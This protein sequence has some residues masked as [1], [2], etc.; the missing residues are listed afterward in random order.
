MYM[1]SKIQTSM[2]TEKSLWNTKNSIHLA[3]FLDK[4]F[5]LNIVLL[6]TQL[7]FTHPQ[8]IRWLFTS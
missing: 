3:S 8:Q 2:N 6:G 4:S 1:H 5:T 7:K